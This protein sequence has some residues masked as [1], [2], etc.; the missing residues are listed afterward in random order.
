[1]ERY[2]VIYDA[3]FVLRLSLSVVH[4]LPMV[5]EI[6]VMNAQIQFTF[7]FVDYEARPDILINT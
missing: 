4:R 6:Y 5:R 7:F 1:M 2:I 3:Y